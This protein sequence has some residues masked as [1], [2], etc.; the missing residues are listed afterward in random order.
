MI[1]LNLKTSITLLLL[2][3][4]A[5]FGISF[6]FNGC[7]DKATATSV[8]IVPVK[9][10]KNNQAILEADYKAKITDLENRNQLFQQELKT[11]KEQLTA[12][13]IKTK[14]RE[15]DIKKRIDPKGF[16]AREL[17]N[18]VN[19]ASATNDSKLSPC[20]SL[21]NEV[22]EYI[23]GNEVKDSLYESQLAI[24]DSV[25]AVKDSVSVAKT[26]LHSELQIL[27]NQSLQQQENLIQENNRFQKKIKRQ[28][29]RNRLITIGI[30]FLSATAAG[31]LLNH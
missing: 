20:D 1:T 6:L 24:L 29:S 30:M 13:R 12:I 4:F 17:L 18:K 31:Y 15:T 9:I 5:G 8:K 23:R 19:L 21:T 22:S 11:A 10:F 16:S 27:L 14:Q 25:I 26:K 28:K 3:F 7:D 2:T